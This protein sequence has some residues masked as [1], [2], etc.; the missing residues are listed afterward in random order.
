MKTPGFTAGASIYKSTGHYMMGV[1]PYSTSP[2]LVTPSATI[3]E[4]F[5]IIGLGPVYDLI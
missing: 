2:S 1:T 4:I 5:T 3:G